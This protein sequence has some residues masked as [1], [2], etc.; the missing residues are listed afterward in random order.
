M[1]TLCRSI[2]WLGEE[3]H[4]RDECGPYVTYPGVQLIAMNDISIL[5]SVA[6]DHEESEWPTLLHLYTRPYRSRV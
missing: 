1:Y 4:V 3:S 2:A 6:S 5:T